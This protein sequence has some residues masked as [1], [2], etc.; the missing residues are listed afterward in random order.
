MEPI[1]E[2]IQNLKR[3]G[4]NL[5]KTIEKIMRYAVQSMNDIEELREEL[6]DLEEIY[7]IIIIDA[8]IDFALEISNGKITYKKKNDVKAP[9]TI[10]FT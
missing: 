4:P 5:N 9:V 1:L 7:D 10:F 2:L 6:K 3:N 8:A